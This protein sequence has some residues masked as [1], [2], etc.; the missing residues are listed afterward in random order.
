MR[1]IVDADACPAISNII[2]TARACGAQVLLVGNETQNLR[3]FKGAKDVA[4]EVVPSDRD[5]ADFAIM[6]GVNAGE[7]VVTNDIGLAAMVLGKGAQ[8]ISPRGSFYN[9]ATIEQELFFRHVGQKVRRAGGRTKGPAPYVE[10]DRER[11]VQ[12][13]KKFLCEREGR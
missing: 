5:A 3:R 11:L 2:K 13:L 10:D 9:N 1:V 12:A 4:I 7:V 8:A 6:L